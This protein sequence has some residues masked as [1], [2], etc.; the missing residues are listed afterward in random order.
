M[1]YLI[2]KIKLLFLSFLIADYNFENI[3]VRDGLSDDQCLSISSDK[4]GFIW[5]GTNE[6]L[7]RFDGYSPKI[8]RSNPFDS[9]ALS[10]NKIFDTYTDKDGDLWI[11]TDKSIDKYLHGSDSFKRF[12]TGTSPTYITEDNNGNIW[13]ATLSNGLFRIN[14][15]NNKVSN[16]KFSPLDPTSISSNQF[17]H[18]QN[19][20]IIVDNNDNLWIATQ[21][22]LNFFDSKSG[23]FKRFYSKKNDLSTIS[24]NIINTI[25]FDGQF[26]WIGS[27]KGLDKIDIDNFS[28]SRESKKNWNSMLGLYHVNQIIPF[29]SGVPM[30]GFWIATIG[31][32][33]YYDKIWEHIRI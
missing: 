4:S 21:N 10:G 19:T 24:S 20:S 15:K 33:I 6:G 13:V 22:G 31:G 14:K 25:Y 2:Y 7:N 17:T 23:I 8:Y 29:K 5:I 26:V 27:S 28:V 12:F 11:S 30:N 1:K 9:T 18:A 32:L 3:T 16:F